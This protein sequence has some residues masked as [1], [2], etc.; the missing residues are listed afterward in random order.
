MAAATHEDTTAELPLD[1]N[2]QTNRPRTASKQS[3][4]RRNYMKRPDPNAKAQENAKSAAQINRPTE[5][6]ASRQTN[7]QTKLVRGHMHP[8]TPTAQP[9]TSEQ[10]TEKQKRN[11]TSKTSKRAEMVA[12]DNDCAQ[13]RQRIANKQHEHM[14][15]HRNE[16]NL[17][18][19]LPTEPLARRDTFAETKS[20]DVH[21]RNKRWWAA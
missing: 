1:N 11:G 5:A 9:Q 15:C 6:P 18:P 12:K 16:I 8:T 21:R 17:E 19:T 13:T 10:T 7:K 20:R 2:K 4:W 14:R 3:S